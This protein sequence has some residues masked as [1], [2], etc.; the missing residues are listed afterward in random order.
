MTRKKK[1]KKEFSDLVKNEIEICYKNKTNFKTE[2][3][4]IFV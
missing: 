3:N 1:K 2:K 4:K